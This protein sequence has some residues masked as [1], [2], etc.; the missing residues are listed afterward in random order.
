M[1]AVK[2]S[3]GKTTTHFLPQRGHVCVSV[4]M[5]ELYL[6]F[7]GGHFSFFAKD[8]SPEIPFCSDQSLAETADSIQKKKVTSCLDG[9]KTEYCVSGRSHVLHLSLASG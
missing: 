3:V 6:Y 9:L 7:Y 2:P 1:Q 8:F 5:C 4:S